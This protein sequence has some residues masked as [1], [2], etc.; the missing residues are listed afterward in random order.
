MPTAATRP[1]VVV[2]EVRWI[3][4]DCPTVTVGSFGVRGTDTARTVVVTDVGLVAGS[5]RL[6]GGDRGR[7]DRRV[8]G[9]NT[10]A[11]RSI[12]PLGGWPSEVC[13]RSTA[14]TAADPSGVQRP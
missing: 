1:G 8:V 7:G 9:S 10:T 12:D 14:A 11:P 2:P 4:T 6:T 13:Q 3:E 5:G